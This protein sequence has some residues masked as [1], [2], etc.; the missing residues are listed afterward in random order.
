MIRNTRVPRG[1]V[2][3]RNLDC[4]CGEKIDVNLRELACQTRRDALLPQVGLKE[5]SMTK[6][7]RLVEDA[8]CGGG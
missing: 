8:A 3:E 1:T 6:G 2:V 5:L 7:G 4:L